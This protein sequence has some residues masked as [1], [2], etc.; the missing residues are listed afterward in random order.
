MADTNFGNLTAG[1]I[2]TWSKDLWRVARNKSFVMQTAGK[3]ENAIIQHIPELTRTK[4]GTAAVM[5]LIAELES[6]GI[7]GD[8]ELEGNEEAIQAFDA[9]ITIDQLRNANRSS[10]KLWE[11]GTVVRF[12]ETSKNVLGYWLADRIDQLAF[13]TM[14]GVAGYTMHTNG[15]IRAADVGGNSFLSLDFAAGVT[16]PSSARHLVI[17][18]ST[19]DIILPV[20]AGTRDTTTVVAADTP[21]YAAM[22]E[23]KAYA[24]S[25]YIRGVIGPNGEET[26][27]V[28]M[29][30]LALAKL[31]LDS[32]FM[33][34]VNN[35]G[36]RGN[37]NPAFSGSMPTVDGLVF[38]EHRHVFNTMGATTGTVTE[39]GDD[40]Y[41]W[42]ATAAVDGSR[43]ILAGAQA[44]GMADLGDPGWTEK[45]FDYGN[46]QGVAT[47]K[48]LGFLKPKYYS[49]VDGSVAAT[50]STYQDFGML[51]IDH[52]I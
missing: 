2:K 19:T 28:Y 26:Y 41:K 15:K 20:A 25:H 32:D 13:L 33:N 42:G 49:Y 45:D 14:A 10:G 11:Q 8:N 23:A 17:D 38:H 51:V 7:N 37:K 31:K 50:P 48:M 35:A 46:K 6:D 4:A 3:G 39:A 34:A 29:H 43:T 40:G 47:D 5:T 9:T 44:L 52:A 36:V 22:V 30:P 16:A 27:H 12:R 18:A 24:K 1:Q 21:T